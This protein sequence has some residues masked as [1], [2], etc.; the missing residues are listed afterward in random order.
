MY[1]KQPEVTKLSGEVSRLMKDV[2]D[3]T[4]ENLQERV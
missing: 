3:Q 4:N 2:S 1:L